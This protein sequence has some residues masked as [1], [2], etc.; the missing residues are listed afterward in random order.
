MIVCISADAKCIPASL[1]LPILYISE[2]RPDTLKSG[3]QYIAAE[4]K[5]GRGERLKRA[6]AHAFDVLDADGVIT[7]PDGEWDDAYAALVDAIANELRAG[8]DFVDSGVVGASPFW[9]GGVYRL[10]TT[11]T[12]G[13]RRTPWC[14][15]RGYSKNVAPILASVKSNGVEYD[16]VLLQAAVTDGVKIT[17]LPAGVSETTVKGKSSASFKS[18]FFGAGGIFMHSTSLKFLASAVIAFVVDYV[19]LLALASMLPFGEKL[20]RGLAKILAWICSSQTN[21]HLNRLLV[22]QKA[23]GLWSAMLQYYSLAGVVLIGKVIGVMVL[24]FIPLWIANLICEAVF[25]LFNYIVQKK[26]I[27]K[28]KK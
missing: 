25:F 21:F 20:S 7:L 24:D 19:L 23:E 22:F 27:F 6:F 5:Q 8:A 4:K 26:L 15:L 11:F 28:K 10:V 2:K 16:T 18:S 13:S 9:L 1:Q 12:T 14:A 3:D 17:D